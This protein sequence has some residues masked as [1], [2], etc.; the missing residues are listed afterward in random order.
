MR[1]RAPRSQQTALDVFVT[2]RLTF[3]RV[4]I[5]WTATRNHCFPEHAQLHADC[6]AQNFAR[7]LERY[8]YLCPPSQSIPLAGELIRG[9]LYESMIRESPY[10]PQ[11][12]LPMTEHAT[13]SEA[14]NPADPALETRVVGRP[15]PPVP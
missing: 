13:S 5:D 7:D 2:G 15:R 12:L 14:F 1:S 3:S 10:Q 4:I 9:L 6:I 11:L 8:L